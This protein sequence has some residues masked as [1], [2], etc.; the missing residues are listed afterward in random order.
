MKTIIHFILITL[1]GCS[2]YACEK[3][4]ISTS[5][6]SN[7]LNLNDPNVAEAKVWF[8]QA[9]KKVTGARVGAAIGPQRKEAEWAKGKSF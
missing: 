2:L 1:L 9:E 5:P 3:T 6:V 8:E 7:T 4:G